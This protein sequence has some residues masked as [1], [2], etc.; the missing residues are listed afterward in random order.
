MS[1]RNIPFHIFFFLETL[2]LLTLYFTFPFVTKTWVKE[3]LASFEQR[4]KDSDSTG[5]GV[6][7]TRHRA[8]ERRDEQARGGLR[9]T[10]H[11]E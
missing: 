3:H 2:S 5:S 4:R 1:Q 10:D 8:S 11:T 6:N 7:G 9:H